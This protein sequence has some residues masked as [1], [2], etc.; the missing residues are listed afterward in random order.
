M[1]MLILLFPQYAAKTH[2]KPSPLHPPDKK[3]VVKEEWGKLMGQKQP[4]R[5]QK[6]TTSMP[7][8]LSCCKVFKTHR[9]FSKKYEF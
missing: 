4:A 9:L 2:P 1:H 8:F 6:V 7:G 5:G 3:W